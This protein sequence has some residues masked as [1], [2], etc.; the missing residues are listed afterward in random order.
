MP[1]FKRLSA[2]SWLILVIRALQAF[3]NFFS[4]PRAVIMA[5]YRFLS[6]LVKVKFKYFQ[7]K[8]QF[9]VPL[10]HSEKKKKEFY[11]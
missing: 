6:F 9:K 11:Y 8:V 7:G 5:L 2:P 3:L 4:L 10:S 1:W